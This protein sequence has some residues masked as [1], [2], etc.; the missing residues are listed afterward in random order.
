MFKIKPSAVL[1]FTVLLLQACSGNGFHLRK[2]VDLPKTYQRIQ[3]E[4]ISYGNSFVKAFELALEESGG[5]LLEQ[6][7]TKIK[8]NNFR[9]GR[10]T[11]A[12]TKE[13]K[14]REFLLFLKFDYT[15]TNGT[16]TSKK[17]RINLDKIF[18]YDADFAL[19]KAEEEKQIKQNLYQEAARLIMLKLQYAKNIN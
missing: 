12:Y 5:K 18:V 7:P 10:R 3:V 9:E 14:A 2:N 6:A 4:N 15:I 19:G 11:V 1:L 17:E 16:K 8:I 13:R